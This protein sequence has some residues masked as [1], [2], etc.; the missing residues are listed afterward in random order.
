[1]VSR[2]YKQFIEHQSKEQMNSRG[3]LS[4]IQ[5]IIN[6]MPTDFK[7]VLCVG[8]GDG[9]E[10]ELFASMGKKVTGIGLNLDRV[11][12]KGYDA[13]QMD[14]HDM[15]F[16]GKTFDMV[17]CKDTFEHSISH[18]IAFSEMV[19]V[20]KKYVYITL[21][22]FDSWKDGEWHYIIPT[23]EQMEALC[24]RFR[25]RFV[26]HE[27]IAVEGHAPQDCYLLERTNES[28]SYVG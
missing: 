16:L 11:S 20:S 18:V 23:K 15:E 26:K 12:Q 4:L 25:V 2:K 17:F 8:L 24:R 13:V 10:C 5:K 14:M 19:R 21:P 6:S 28:V 7:S 9:T 22:D 3:Q 27:R 1:M